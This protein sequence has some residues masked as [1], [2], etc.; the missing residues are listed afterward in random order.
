MKAQFLILSM[1]CLLGFAKTNAQTQVL[2]LIPEQPI[3]GEPVSL[4]IQA[5]WV[6]G[7]CELDSAEVDLDSLPIIKVN[8]RYAVGFLTVICESVDTISLG[9]LPPSQEISP[10]VF[11]LYQINTT[12]TDINIP[13]F[14]SSDTLFFF[15]Q[16]SP[17]AIVPL[18]QEYTLQNLG[19]GNYVLQFKEAIPK[20]SG[21]LL[22]SQGR[23]IKEIQCLGNQM[24]I[25]LS[26]E[27]DGIYSLISPNWSV[28]FLHKR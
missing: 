6:S 17:T 22:D 12:L 8:A 5:T 21:Q 16:P 10:G 4:V 13:S 7:G 11:E 28:R 20:L 27:S 1:C 15:V 9:I 26:A 24:S 18:K 23:K 2:S 14:S 19:N 3:E 25:D